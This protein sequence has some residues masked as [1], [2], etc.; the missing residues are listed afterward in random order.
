MVS[1]HVLYRYN[2]NEFQVEAAKLGVPPN[3]KL[4]RKEWS[5][6][7]RSIRSRPR[8]FSK[9]FIRSETEKLAEYRHAVRQ[10]QASP[11]QQVRLSYDVPAYIPVGA[12]VTAFHSVFRSVFRGIV[13]AHDATRNGYLVQF[14]RQEL[15]YQFCLDTEVASHGAPQILVRATDVTL[16]GTTLGAFSNRHAGPGA[17]AYGTS[18]GAMYVD[19]LDP[20]ERDKKAKDALLDT[21]MAAGSKSIGTDSHDKTQTLSDIFNS[22]EEH[23][24]SSAKKFDSEAALI[25]K[26]AERETLVQLMGTIVAALKRKTMLLDA[27]EKCHQLLETDDGSQIVF[28]FNHVFKDHYSWLQANLRMTNLSLESCLLLLQAMYS[29]GYSGM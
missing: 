7:R 20:V 24:I 8:R 28:K 5:L 4:T 29:G 21:V 23:V 6:V 9:D 14:E 27:I 15:G 10:I 25:E 18:Y 19:Q 13:L 3:A 17:L 1:S 12:T 26:V 16:D 11:S 2:V 22:D